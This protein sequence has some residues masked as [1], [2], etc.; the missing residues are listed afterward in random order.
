[1][2]AARAMNSGSHGCRCREA[3]PRGS[4]ARSSEAPAHVHRAATP[5]APPGDRIIA[6]SL[7]G[8]GDHFA[9]SLRFYS[10]HYNRNNDGIVSWP[11]E[12]RRGWTGRRRQRAGLEKSGAPGAAYPSAAGSS[13]APRPALHPLPRDRCVDAPQGDPPRGGG[14]ARRD[15]AA[16]FGVEPERGR[17]VSQQR[18]DSAE[19]HA[20]EQRPVQQKLQAYV[21]QHPDREGGDGARRP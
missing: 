11:K 6:I 3:P 17:T 4:M 15:S 8:K 7:Q 9:S 10:G 18:Q 13:R 1:M 5:G 12:R 19:E 14:K 2:A 20:F 21:H 16:P